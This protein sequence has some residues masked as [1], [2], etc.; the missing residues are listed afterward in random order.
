LQLLIRFIGFLI[1]F[2]LGFF[3]SLGFVIDPLG[4]VINPL[5]FD[6]DPLGF[7]IDPFFSLATFVQV[8]VVKFVSSISYS[9]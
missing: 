6:I 5:D 8:L 3:K 4:F 2:F 7:V 9:S 1:E